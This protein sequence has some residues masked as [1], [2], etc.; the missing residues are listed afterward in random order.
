MSQKYQLSHQTE[1]LIKIIV[2]NIY[3]PLLHDVMSIY[4]I[5]M[6]KY[7]I[8]E[9]NCKLYCNIFR[10][11]QLIGTLSFWFSNSCSV[12][13]YYEITYKSETS[14]SYDEIDP[15]SGFIIGYVEG[16]D[17]DKIDTK[18]VKKTLQKFFNRVN[19]Y[20]ENQVSK[21]LQTLET[22]L[23]TQ[24]LE[25]PLET[26]PQETQPCVE[27]ISPELE[28]SDD[29]KLPVKNSRIPMYTRKEFIEILAKTTDIVIL[30]TIN[31]LKKNM[32]QFNS[33]KVMNLC[34]YLEEKEKNNDMMFFD[35][36]LT[37]FIFKK[38]LQEEL[39]KFGLKYKIKGVKKVLIHSNKVI[40]H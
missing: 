40:V 5:T 23:E 9:E 19:E 34:P 3:I 39:E 21:K 12:R 6:K 18:M 29:S 38:K 24:T 36:L 31:F 15:H 8:F 13:H 2:D 10:E 35:K 1:D 11:N 4:D 20:E 25:T 37:N 28:K 22:P 26:Q 32:T 7:Q 16:I 17:V 30:R 27:V 14:T 33:G